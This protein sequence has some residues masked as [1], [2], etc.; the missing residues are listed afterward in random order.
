MILIEDN[1]MSIANYI[2]SVQNMSVQEYVETDLSQIAFN[3]EESRTG[4]KKYS[5]CAFPLNEIKRMYHFDTITTFTQ[6]YCYW[7]ARVLGHYYNNDSVHKKVNNDINGM[8][9]LVF[10]NHFIYKQNGKYYDIRGDI[11]DIVNN[12]VKN[13]DEI[14]VP[15]LDYKKE[16]ILHTYKLYR[17]CVYKIEPDE[18]DENYE[19]DEN[20]E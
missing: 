8:W 16:D 9:Y 10:E 7:F 5:G 11:T 6:G 18:D 19:L 17:D 3:D 1:N 20:Y 12:S 4:F 2:K 14:V 13:E 15:W